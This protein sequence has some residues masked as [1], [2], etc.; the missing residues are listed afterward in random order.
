MRDNRWKLSIK[1]HE[2]SFHKAKKKL[3]TL[4]T[5]YLIHN[6]PHSHSITT[7][8]VWSLDSDMKI[9]RP[10]NLSWLKNVNLPNK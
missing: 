6:I 8:I 4:D 7:K 10:S 1:K 9:N 3:F 2:I 5:N